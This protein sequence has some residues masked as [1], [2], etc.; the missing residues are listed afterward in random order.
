VSSAALSPSGRSATLSIAAYTVFTRSA[1]CQRMLHHLRGVIRTPGALVAV[2]AALQVVVWTITP[3]I[4]NSAPPLDVVESYMWGREWVLATY[5]HPAMPSWV[6]EASRLLAGGAIGW[7]AYLAAQLF[8]A[9]T[10]ALVFALGRDVMRSPHRAAV[11]TLL[12]A[13]LPV[14]TWLSP[15]FNHNIALLPFWAGIVL[16]LWRAIE[17]CSI[18]WWVVVGALAAAGLYAKFTTVILLIAASAW[19]VWD[20]KARESLTTAGPWSGV[21]VFAAITA[22]LAVW[23]LDHQ[24]APLTYASERAQLNG[25][26][27][28]RPFLWGSLANLLAVLVGLWIAGLLKGT[29]D[30][31]GSSD[32]TID[33]RAM[34]FL[35]ILLFGPLLLTVV[36]AAATG[37]GLRSA[38]SNSMFNLAVLF[39]VGLLS[40]R[41]RQGTLKRLGILIAAL[42]VLLPLG[43]ALIFSSV[44]YTP[45]KIAR[46][47]WSQAEIAHTFQN[48]WAKVTG[49]L[50]LRIVTGRNWV[51]G[52]VGLT[53][54]GGP[55]ILSGGRLDRSPWV[56]LERIEREGMLIV[57]DGDEKNLPVSLEHYRGHQPSGTELFE[58]PGGTSD[59]VI[60][61][62]VVMPRSVQ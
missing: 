26:P 33:P 34:Q 37:S 24:F 40:Q 53:A 8:I 52:L 10:F 32:R 59:I 43:Y 9:V 7:P 48:I 60:H 57:W 62:I 14:Y 1:L 15:E 54:P 12:L 18:G 42:L 23:L 13:A 21:A 45:S 17:R 29:R 58:V 38:W 4:I 30:K 27:D 16:G 56:S 61:W 44:L 5:K 6:L 49:G 25:D 35:A 55:S 22:P 3:A 41:V 36:I 50:P 51:A 19:I 39:A 20:R 11:G 31:S 2:A 47:Q 28:L 46:V